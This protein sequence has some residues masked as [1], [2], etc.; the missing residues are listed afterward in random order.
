MKEK[1]WVEVGYCVVSDE[2]RTTS[3]FNT[4]QQAEK[5]AEDYNKSHKQFSAEIPKGE[6]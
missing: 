6:R 2:G 5:E 3:Y 1:Y 4:K